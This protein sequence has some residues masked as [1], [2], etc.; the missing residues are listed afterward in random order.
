M[1]G[2]TTKAVVLLAATQ[3]VSAFLHGQA[4]YDPGGRPHHH[5]HHSHPSSKAFLHQSTTET[6]QQEHVWRP[7]DLTKDNPGFLPIPE[8][9]YIK[10]YQANP[11]ELWPVEFFVVPYRRVLNEQSGKK[12]TQILVR[13][14]ANGT[15]KWGLGTGVPV[16]RWILDTASIP[17]GYE[18]KTPV[19]TFEAKNFPEFPAQD[20]ILSWQY[21]K[22]DICKDVFEDTSRVELIDPVLHNY[23]ETIRGALETHLSKVNDGDS[24][25]DN[26][27]EKIRQSVTLNVVKDERSTAAIQGT[28]RMSGLFEG[29]DDDSQPAPTVFSESMRV[30]TMYPQMPNPM[31]LPNSS[32]KELK[33]ELCSR[34]ERMARCARDPHKDEYGRVF[35]HKSTSN[36]S[37]TIHGIYLSIDAT[38]FLDRNEVPSALDLFGTK[39]IPKEW[40][41]LQDLEVLAKDGKEIS[42]TDPKPTFI[43][44]FIY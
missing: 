7:Q 35:T 5:H 33:E 41:S 25:A 16:T 9:D 26:S 23:A 24:A 27:W 2:S 15:S 44:A 22:I 20:G 8:H 30:Y 4:R 14:S 43:S 32:P 17:F 6:C 29:N 42:T 19:V 38:D 18:W 37:N 31:P 40:K 10:Q 21:R 39:R 12:E 34:E 1:K 13:P 11:L 28:L 3:D 36:V